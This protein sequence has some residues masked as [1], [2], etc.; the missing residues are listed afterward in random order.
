MALL[1]PNILIYDFDGVIV[2]SREAVFKFYDIICKRF[3]LPL[4]DRKN[5]ELVEKILMFTTKKAINLLCQDKGAVDNILEYINEIDFTCLREFI[6][7][8]PNI[9]ETL[10][11]LQ[12]K[13]YKISLFTNRGDSTYTLLKHFNI[14]SYFDCIVTSM[15][16]IKPKPSG[17]GLIK[18]LDYFSAN[19][20]ESL[21]IGDTDFDYFASIEAGVPFVFY[22]NNKNSLQTKSEDF[23]NSTYHNPTTKTLLK[24]SIDEDSK[25]LCIY[26]HKE[27]FHYLE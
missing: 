20:T 12:S 24:Q 23:T 18:I 16:V 6:F 10:K 21:Y 25:S 1:S 13:G 27:I 7:L 17:E 26:D 8:Q 19:N 4:I 11:L 2:D 5:K 15:D 14:Y 3:G 9:E 22:N